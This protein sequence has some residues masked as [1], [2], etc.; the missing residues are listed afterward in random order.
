MLGFHLKA[1]WPTAEYYPLTFDLASGQILISYDLQDPQQLILMHKMM[2][3]CI[4][5]LG[6][7]SKIVDN[8]P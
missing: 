3:H 1:I 2:K 4:L 7:S 8:S 6:Q 5:S